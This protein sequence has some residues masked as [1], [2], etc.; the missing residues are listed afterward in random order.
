MSRFT[1]DP[2][3][4]LSAFISPRKSAPALIVDALLD[5]RIEIVACPALLTEL[6]DV[7]SR[8]KFAK[9]T[10]QRH[11]EAYLAALEPLSR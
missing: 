4:L 2:G 6:S 1:V 11:G 3:V 5:G 10:E 7:L 9:H 8:P